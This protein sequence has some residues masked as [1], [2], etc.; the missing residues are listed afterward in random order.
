[1]ATKVPGFFFMS[2]RQIQFTG[3]NLL[4]SEYQYMDLVNIARETSE[5]VN[6]KYDQIQAN[7]KFTNGVP[8]DKLF[9][10]LT[11]GTSALVREEI[12]NGIRAYF[13]DDFTFLMDR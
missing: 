8:K 10:K 4:I 13:K 7:Y 9:V 3:P 11:P 1:M 5:K 2:Y 6:E 12:A